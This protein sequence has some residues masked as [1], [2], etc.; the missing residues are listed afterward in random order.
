[1]I[2]FDE[3][4]KSEA[5]L[6]L[7]Y[8]P[9]LGGSITLKHIFTQ[10]IKKAEKLSPEKFEQSHPD[11]SIEENGQPK[12]CKVTYSFVLDKHPSDD[13]IKDLEEGELKGFDIIERENISPG[14]DEDSYFKED[15]LTLSVKVRKDV[16]WTKQKIRAI[17]DY[18]KNHKHDGKS[19]KIRF[20][21][22]DGLDKV[23]DLDTDNENSSLYVKKSIISDFD[24]E[25]KSSY[26]AINHEM[27]NKMATL[28]E[29]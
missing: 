23:V 28:L 9:G 8:C 17:K 1:M 18:I 24:S 11:G 4:N 6:L 26:D 3:N 12:K 25:L 14:F 15:R 10:L 19:T 7:E 13:F 22:P 5:I 27:I 20:K 2:K 21:S 29:N 16:N